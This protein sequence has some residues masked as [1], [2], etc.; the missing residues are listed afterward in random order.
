MSDTMPK[1]RRYLRRVLYTLLAASFLFAATTATTYGL[2]RTKTISVREISPILFEIDIA[3]Y[4]LKSLLQNEEGQYNSAI[5]LMN[6]A[7]FSQQYAQPG[8]DMMRHLAY[9]NYPPAQYIHANVIMLNA[10]NEIER[11]EAMMFY[12]DAADEG[13]QP[14]QA[15]LLELARLQ[16]LGNIGP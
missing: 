13:Y 6:S 7:F 14:A 4:K 12:Q 1:S 2:V 5:R 8:R 3:T 16:P 15:R 9:R 11:S 10:P